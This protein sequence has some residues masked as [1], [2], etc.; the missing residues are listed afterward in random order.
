M[1]TSI[2]GIEVFTVFCYNLINYKFIG[3]I[4][5]YD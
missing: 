5:K 4:N 1:M 2:K 3:G